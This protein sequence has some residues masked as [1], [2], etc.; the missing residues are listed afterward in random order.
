MLRFALPCTALMTLAMAACAPAPD[1]QQQAVDEAGQRAE[2]DAKPAAQPVPVDAAAC[3]AVQ[4]KWLEGK[5]PTEAEVEQARADSG[6]ESV[7]VL[8]P[9]QMVTME[10]NASRLNIDVDDAGAVISVRCG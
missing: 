10:F 2:A 6:A 4:A 9:D 7:R 8:K 1:E 5:V 3:D